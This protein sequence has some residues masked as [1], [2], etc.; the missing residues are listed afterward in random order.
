[1]ESVTKFRGT[2]LVL[3]LVVVLGFFALKLYDLQILETGGG[4][5]NNQATFTTLTRVKAARGDILDKNGNLLVSNRA[6]YDLNI[7]HYVLLTADN[8]NANLLRLVKRCEEAG[9]VYKEHFPL[10]NTL[11]CYTRETKCEKLLVLC[12][13]SDKP[14]NL[15]IPA[16]YDLSKGELILANYEDRLPKI[17]QPYE[18]RVYRFK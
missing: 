4:N 17:L 13:F 7:N 12:S 15:R 3:V 9:I 11:Y 5:T 18:C 2:I 14:Q 10:S 8:T 1:M 6:S 16:G